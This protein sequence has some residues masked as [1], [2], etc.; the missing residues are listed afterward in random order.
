MANYNQNI[1]GGWWML[2]YSILC[3]MAP[4]SA[5]SEVKNLITNH[6]MY[7]KER[8]MIHDHTIRHTVP[9]VA[10]YLDGIT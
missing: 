3:L 1:T 5:F 7:C 6:E 10:I 4:V 2:P 9:L 8:I